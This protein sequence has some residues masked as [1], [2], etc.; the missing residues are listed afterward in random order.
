MREKIVL[1][2]SSLYKLSDHMI[3]LTYKQDSNIELQDAIDT[4]NAI[5]ELANGKPY[6][7]LVDF[8]GLYG[9]MTNEARI[10]Y[11]TDLKTRDIRKAEAL[12]L[13]N[14]PAR[15]IARFYIKV[16]K[17][18][19]PVKIFAKKQKALDWLEEIYASSLILEPT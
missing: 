13:D 11:A 5:F 9:N 2:K 16:N 17:P 1:P 19:N 18:N 7:V 4:N 14:L 12:L 8:L 10:H 15:I 6:T 3:Y